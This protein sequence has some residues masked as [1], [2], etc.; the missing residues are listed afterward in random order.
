MQ[1]YSTWEGL[2]LGALV[3][4]VIFWMMPG[5]KAA[6]QQSKQAKPDWQGFLVPLALVVLFVIFLLATV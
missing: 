1:T 4:L 3:L 6:M 2:L 5:I